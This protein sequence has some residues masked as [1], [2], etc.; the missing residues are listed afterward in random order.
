MKITGSNNYVK[1]VWKW[2]CYKSGRRNAYGEKVCGIYEYYEN[3][4]TTTWEWKNQQ[5]TNR[6][7][8]SRSTEKYELKYGEDYFWM[9]LVK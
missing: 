8:N 7:N 1:F 9:K 3:M 5:G 2:V 4:G 6:K